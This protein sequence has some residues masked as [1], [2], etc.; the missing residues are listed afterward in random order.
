MTPRSTE[1]TNGSASSWLESRFVACLPVCPRDQVLG[2]R[3]SC[4]NSAHPIDASIS[5]CPPSTPYGRLSACRIRPTRAAASSSVAVPSETTTNSSP[6]TRDRVRGAD[7]RL[8]AP[9]DGA[10]HLVR[11]V[12]AHV[13]DALESVQVDDEER[14][15]L[16]RPA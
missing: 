2:S 11:L 12:T 16:L 4:G 10:Q 8:E 14:E 13:V 15:Q 9:P 5:T 3:P 6:P 7:D 1:R